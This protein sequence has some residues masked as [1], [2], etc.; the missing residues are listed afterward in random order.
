M[1]ENFEILNEKEKEVVSSLALLPVEFYSI[2]E[3]S[4]FFFVENFE[5]VTFFD[6]IHDLSIKGYLDT[7]K[8]LYAIKST[9]AESILE[10][11][12]PGIEECPRIV[13]Y[14]VN[15]L[16]LPRK[17]GEATFIHLYRQLSYLLQKIKKNSLHLA[18]LSYLLSSSLVSYKKYNEALYYNEL[19]V[20]ISERIDERHPLVALF[21]RDKAYI[22]KKLGNPKKSIIYSLKDIEI[23]ERHE[24]KYDDLLPDS[25]IALS[26]TY[27][28]V[29]NYKKAIEYNLKAI[30]YEQKRTSERPLNLS[31]LYQNLAFYYAKLNNLHHASL[32]I[33]KAVESFTQER[34]KGNGEYMQL[35][36]DQKKFNSLYEIELIIRKLKYPILIV[37]GL[38]ICIFFWI[39]YKIFFILLL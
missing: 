21:Y 25:Y 15:K 18:Q 26:K 4:S 30:K 16:E 7:S 22:H 17:E 19:A 20:E 36:R 38:C 3:L 5:N 28:V 2:P 11:V 10:N 33:N 29:H 31:Y 12:N 1:I 35:K 24:G 34:K 13:N 27:E 39:L 37:G 8:G 14:F 9:I 32:F 23:L 6:T